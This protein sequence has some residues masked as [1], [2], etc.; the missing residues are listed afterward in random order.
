M[1]I[2]IL[3]YVIVMMIEVFNFVMIVMVIVVFNM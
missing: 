2:V 3:N 1:K